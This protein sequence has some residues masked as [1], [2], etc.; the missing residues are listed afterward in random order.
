MEISRDAY[1][2]IEDIVGPG[3][4]T[5]D[6]AFLDSYAFEWLAE[7]VRPNRSH[8]MPRPWAV[9]MPETTKEVQAVTKLCNKYKIK[10]KPISTGWYHWAAPMK[11]NE[12]TVQFDLRRMNKIIDIDE[13]NRFAIVEPYVICAQ[14]QAEA[15]KLG[16]N[17]NIIG[18][19]SSTSI[20]ASASAY[21][22]GGPSSYYMGNNSDNLL[23]QEWVTPAG[24]IVR[25]GSLSSGAGWFCGEGPGP[26]VRALTRGSLGSR[27]GLGTYTKSCIKLSDWS[28]PRELKP[29]GRPPGYRLPVP[30]NM[31]AYTI[32]APSWEAWANC[33]FSIYDNGIGYIFHRQFNL[34]GADLAAALWLTYIDPTKTMN[35]V[36]IASKDPKI[37]QISEQARISFQLIMA[38]QTIEGIQLQD[39]ILDKILEQTGCYKVERFCEKDMAEFTNMY[40]Q[41]LGHKH[42]NFIW[43]GGYM[44]S[45]MQAGTPDYVKNYVPVAIDGFYR[46]QKG[47]KLVECGG[48]A[49]MG[50]GSTLGGGGY[51]GLEQFVSYDPNDNDSIDACIKHME[52]AI[53]DCRREGIPVGKEYLYLQIGW[54]DEQIWDDLAKAPQKFVFNFQ[55]KFKEAVDPNELGDRNYVWLPEGWGE[56]TNR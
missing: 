16:L 11:D 29:E 25:T 30:E 22:G 44:G 36:E 23:G 33:Y 9:V 13:K 8:Y 14:L 38:D 45:W 51:F 48:D 50:C 42:C 10:V 2:A 28:G 39:K 52:D 12:P 53:A 20:V 40:L 27:G 3:N 21:F 26:S 32:G 15:L 55:R 18:A 43:V 19:G 54:K 49:M 31:R 35:D 37:Q 24:K 47:H 5:D 46:D 17:L 34:A 41:R 4:V 6:P 56:A 7:L 1:R